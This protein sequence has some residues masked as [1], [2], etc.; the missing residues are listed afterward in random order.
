MKWEILAFLAFLMGVVLATVMDNGEKGSG[1]NYIVPTEEIS[2]HMVDGLKLIKGSSY[3]N[4]TIVI[5]C[6]GGE[7]TGYWRG[8]E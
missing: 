1:G 5:Q 6:K 4:S 3:P 8:V 2:G 7:C